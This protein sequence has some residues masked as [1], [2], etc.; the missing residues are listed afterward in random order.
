MN[1]HFYL[2]ISEMWAINLHVHTWSSCLH[3]MISCFETFF[4]SRCWHSEIIEIFELW[5]ASAI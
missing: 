3:D 4:E 2:N 5:L 1:W